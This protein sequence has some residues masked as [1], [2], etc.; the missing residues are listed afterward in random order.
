VTGRGSAANSLVSYCLG[1]TSP[2]PFEHRPLFARFMHEGRKDPPDIDLD[3]CSERRDEVRFEMIRRYERLGVAE[4]ATVQTMSLRGAVRVAARALGHSPQEIDELC[5]RVPTRFQDRN[6]VYEGLSGWEEA[7]AE[8]AMRGH[9]LQDTTR[10][11]LL[12]ELSARLM[13][14]IREAGTHSG[15]MV[16]GTAEWHLSELVPLEPLG[17]EGLLR[18]QY[19]KEDLERVGV[20]KLDLLGLKMHTALRKAGELASQRLGRRV[21]PYDPPSNDTETY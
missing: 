16:S 4:A 6:K 2:E 3:F 14:R 12:L 21:D 18:C 9:P 10:H 17:A 20:P 5:R 8:P 19:D 13:G 15:G 1:L 11:R 7:L